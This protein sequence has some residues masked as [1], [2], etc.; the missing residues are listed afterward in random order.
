MLVPVRNPNGKQSDWHI[1]ASEMVAG[2]HGD[3]LARHCFSIMALMAHLLLSHFGISA[4]NLSL[5]LKSCYHQ[6]EPQLAKILSKSCKVSNNIL[7]FV[8]V[9]HNFTPLAAVVVMQRPRQ[10]KR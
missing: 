9:N 5:S 2:G 3:C 8:S 10:G 7:N 4:I 1:V 6:F